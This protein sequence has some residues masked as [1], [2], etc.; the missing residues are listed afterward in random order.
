M[1]IWS[2]FLVRLHTHDYLDRP[3]SFGAS[4]ASG[5]GDLRASLEGHRSL[6][7]GER[8]I[9]ILAVSWAV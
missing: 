1:G 5:M 6:R 9:R 8:V 4:G 3:A 2:L 7:P